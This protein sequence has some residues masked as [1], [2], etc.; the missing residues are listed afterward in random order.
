MARNKNRVKQK[1]KGQGQQIADLERA[2]HKSKNASERTRAGRKP[3]HA[4]QKVVNLLGTRDQQEI[5]WIAAM[6][7][8]ERYAARVPITQVTGAVPVDNFRISS[9]V[10][11]A[12][13][14][15]G[16]SFV[17][18]C[19]DHWYHDSMGTA[20]PMGQLHANG[21]AAYFGAATGASYAAGTW[22]TASSSMTVPA[23]GVVPIIVPD[24][25]ADFQAAANTGT[26]YIMVGN[27]LSISMINP[28]TGNSAYWGEVWAITS[29]DVER[30]PIQGASPSAIESDSLK[31]GSLYRLAKYKITQSGLFVPEELAV[32]GEEAPFKDDFGVASLSVHST[33]LMT[34]AYKWRRCEAANYQ[35]AFGYPN[36]AFYVYAPSGTGYKV[37]HT[38]LWQ[39]ERYA[40]A[41]VRR[42]PVYSLN[43]STVS[44]LANL[45]SQ[46]YQMAQAGKSGG[47]HTAVASSLLNAAGQTPGF[48][49]QLANN[50][51]GLGNLVNSGS[52]LASALGGAVKGG[53]SLLDAIKGYGSYQPSELPQ[54]WTIGRP[55]SSLP[56]SSVSVIEETGGSGIMGTLEAGAEDALEFA[57]DLLAILA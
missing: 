49:N 26:E 48:L 37:R 10:L 43:S 29:M 41:L 20:I 4:V 24:I 44:Q 50:I 52:Q 16:A 28:G 32:R 51:Q 5:A 9:S 12:T 17:G 30:A 11:G 57:P 47:L 54:G 39:T 25:S 27:K 6:T 35:V 31:D 19:P 23:T 18:T 8:C 2:A 40:S 14:S 53:S 7:D 15:A 46:A 55:P 1:L 21:G 33:P 3:K 22:P 13:N 38:A 56:A 36:C 34:G 45:A 42:T